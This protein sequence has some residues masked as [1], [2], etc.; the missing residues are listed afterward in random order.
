M[1]DLSDLPLD[2]AQPEVQDFGGYL[3]PPLGGPVQRIDRVGTRWTMAFTTPNLPVEPDLRLWSA[4]LA[5]GKK[6]GVLI[7]IPEPDLAAPDYGM[8]RIAVAVTGGS[9]V[10]IRGLPVGTLIVEGKWLSV[11]HDARRYL[12]RAAAD[13]V[14]DANGIAVVR[15]DPMLRTDLAAGDV[16]ELAVAKMQGSIPA[17]FRWAVPLAR[18]APLGFTVVEDE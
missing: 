6:E 14:A 18:F 10:R 17:A 16:V 11:I 3:T 15:L 7:W 1:I 9:V 8:P 12:Y 5:R 4:R 13:T 2:D